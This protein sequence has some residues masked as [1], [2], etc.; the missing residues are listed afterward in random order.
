MRNW[1]IRSGHSH[2]LCKHCNMIWQ[3]WAALSIS[4]FYTRFQCYVHRRHLRSSFDMP[5]LL[6]SENQSS[7][8]IQFRIF[9][10]VTALRLLFC[11]HFQLTNLGGSLD[12]FASNEPVSLVIVELLSTASAT[13]FSLKAKLYEERQAFGMIGYDNFERE[14]LFE[15]GL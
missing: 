1:P 13:A 3:K 2:G 12:L 15:T 4:L 11:W 5:W 7:I 6:C 14:G 10:R 8:V 9:W